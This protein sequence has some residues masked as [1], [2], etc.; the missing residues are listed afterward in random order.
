[1]STTYTYDLDSFSDLYKEA[2]GFRPNGDYLMHVRT[3]SDEVRQEEWDTLIWSAN[4]REQE[5]CEDEAHALAELKAQLFKTMDDHNVDIATAI[6]W[7]D[8]AHGTQGD[9]QFLDYNLGV[10]YGT[11]ETMLGFKPRNC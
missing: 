7:L 9:W 10:K 4:L 6:R 11:I 2:Y 1:M 8:D 5:R 3:A